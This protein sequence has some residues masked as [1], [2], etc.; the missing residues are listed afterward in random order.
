MPYL[1]NVVYLLLLVLFSPWLLY[2]AIRK[3]K[4]REGLGAKFLGRLPRRTGTGRCIW[5]HAVSVGEINVL[6]TLLLQLEQEHPTWECVISTTTK[7]GYALAKK[8]YAPR[9]VFYCPL[10]FSWAVN[11]ALRSIRPDLLLLVEL[12]LWPNLIW[13]AQRQNVKVAIVN[14]RLSEHSLRGYCRIRSFVAAVLRSLDLVA[15]QNT[16]YAERFR[17]L[18]ARPETTQV[19]GSIKFDGAETDRGNPKT[20]RLAALWGLQPDDV[21]FLAGSTQH[22]EEAL[23]L[24]VY[25]QLAPDHPRLRLIL[26]PR[27]S[28]RFAD[29]AELLDQCGVPWQ[30]RS[31]LETQGPNPAARILLIDTI[32][33]L[34]A[35]WG[36]GRIAYVG[37]SLGRRGGQN[38]I[39]PAAYGSAVS[40]G[41][42]TSNFRDVVAMLL[43]RQAAV[44]VQDAKELTAFVRR[45]IDEP[46]FAEELGRRAQQLVTEQ[47]G[48]A[49]RT[50]QLIDLLLQ[51]DPDQPGRTTPKPGHLTPTSG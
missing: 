25:R 33:E 27:H 42:N 9:P 43:D 15:V 31:T 16:E 37:G 35:W 34:A 47:L 30:R 4:Y 44:V 51:N 13:A 5:L 6:G 32:G 14:G 19:T 23:A 26:T 38:M 50:S 22:P 8:K 11:R 20:Q 29:V 39:E 24:E 2:A 12:E 49:Q 28:E 7:T 48:A 45:C 46:T 17:Q 10:D 40:F 41:P 36:A 21:V 18:G 1:L 3:G